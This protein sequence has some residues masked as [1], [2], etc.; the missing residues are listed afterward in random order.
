MPL[1]GVWERAEGSCRAPG[2]PTGGGA[3]GYGNRKSFKEKICEPKNEKNAKST[4][5][6]DSPRLSLHG[7]LRLGAGNI[8]LSPRVL[9][10]PFRDRYRNP[11]GG[12][13]G[14]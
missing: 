10:V 5:W 7:N 4:V 1:V 3:G 9:K 6:R 12:S 8:L 2:N 13:R 11:T 14:S